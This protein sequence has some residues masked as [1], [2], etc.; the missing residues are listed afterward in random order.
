MN[1]SVFILVA[2]LASV[3]VGFWLV[4]ASIAHLVSAKGDGKWWMASGAMIGAVLVNSWW[5][6]L[7]AIAAFKLVILREDT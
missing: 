4:A 6:W 5:L 1:A 2:V 7:F 3:G